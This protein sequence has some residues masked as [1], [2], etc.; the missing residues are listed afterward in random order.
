MALKWLPKCRT[1]Q[2]SGRSS[3]RSSEKHI[4]IYSPQS[5]YAL[6]MPFSLTYFIV[7]YLLRLIV[8]P[9]SPL[10]LQTAVP[11]KSS[12]LNLSIYQISASLCNWNLLV[13]Q[14]YLRGRLILYYFSKRYVWAISVRVFLSL[15][16]LW[17]PLAHL[18]L[19]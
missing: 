14:S 12:F 3:M 10:H 11:A 13:L 7:L 5:C 19:L 9:Y 16:Q 6:V 2:K 4:H 15:T 1:Q 17:A 18:S 8:I